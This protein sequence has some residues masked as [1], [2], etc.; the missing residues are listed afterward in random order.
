MVAEAE[1]LLFGQGRI[2]LRVTAEPQKDVE[3]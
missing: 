3:E 1:V 2:L